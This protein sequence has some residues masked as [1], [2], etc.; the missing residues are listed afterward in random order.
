MMYVLLLIAVS[1]VP[2]LPLLQKFFWSDDWYILS[3][4][5]ISSLGEFARFF[6]F[7]L[8]EHVTP[9]YRPLSTEA[10]Y[11]VMHRLFGLNPV[12]FHLVGFAVWALGGYMLYLLM[13]EIHK[14]DHAVMI[15]FFYLF[16]ASH[17][18]RLSY[19]SAFQE[20]LM[21]TAGISAL[22]FIQKRRF[23]ISLAL[24]I[25]ALLSKESAVI[26]FPLMLLIQWYTSKGKFHVRDFRKFVAF[27]VIFVI[28]L[29]GRFVIRGVG[30]VGAD[31]VWD[32]SPVRAL[33][34]AVWYGLWSLG[35]PEFVIDYVGSGAQVIPR[36]W[37]D[38]AASAYMMVGG[39]ILLGC[40]FGGAFLMWLRRYILS[41]EKM[42]YIFFCLCWY[43]IA[44]APL[45]FLPTHKYALGQSLALIGVAM[46]LA[47]IVDSA[48]RLLKKSLI[49]IFVIWNLLSISLYYQ[50]H[51]SMQR[52][53][54][55]ER[56]YSFV[57]EEYPVAPMGF[58]FLNDSPSG[59]T[60]WGQ[61]RQ[62]YQALGDHFFEVVYRVGLIP[63]SMY[64]DDLTKAPA[65]FSQ[66]IMLPS[67]RFL[68]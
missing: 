13:K 34:T 22:Y 38:F 30:G 53:E 50:H 41:A 61:S 44:L 37:T 31:Y 27:F 64:E 3:L 35:L 48:P 52:S 19:L 28:Y 23:V 51:V 36:F 39:F 68:R 16:S 59:P 56:V 63:Q 40:A 49:V 15:L 43:F 6:S 2:Y 26:I 67:S 12:P 14:K 9:V 18:T 60:Q 21:F 8:S 5:N 65:D 11:F 46:I 58:Y 62:I 45:I 57:R 24:F 25:A 32:F 29:Y 55:S 4:T 17:F 54:I 20:V 47:E 10:F 33:H 7:R 1:L 42:R 66:W